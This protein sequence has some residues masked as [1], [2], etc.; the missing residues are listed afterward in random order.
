[1]E[2]KKGD[3]MRTNELYFATASTL[4][5]LMARDSTMAYHHRVILA[6]IKHVSVLCL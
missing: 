6:M 4:E 1:M 3:T 5:G 2:K